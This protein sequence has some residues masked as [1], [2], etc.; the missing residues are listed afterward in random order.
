M[1]RG[2]WLALMMVF[3][4]SGARA[5]EPASA[6]EGHASSIAPLLPVRIGAHADLTWDGELG[7]G[8]RVDI[9]ILSKGVLFGTRDELSVSVGMDVVFEAFE[10][11]D[12]LTF[13]PTATVQWTLGLTP[14]FSFFPELGL[15]A[16]IQRE[17]MEGVLPNIGFGGRYHVWRSVAITGRLGWPMAISL[18]ACF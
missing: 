4:A 1:F 15:A 16:E 13:W 12:P 8:G 10:G 2:R 17:G 14:R 3:V 9:P 6:E 11:S 18:G 5:D 7:V